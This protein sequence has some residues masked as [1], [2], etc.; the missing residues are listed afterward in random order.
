MR[1]ASF[2]C[3]TLPADFR[4]GRFHHYIRGNPAEKRFVGLEVNYFIFV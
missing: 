4:R 1:T 3:F 2:G